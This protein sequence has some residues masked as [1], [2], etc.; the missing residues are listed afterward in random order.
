MIENDESPPGLGISL[1][2][3]TLVVVSLKPVRTDKA[4]ISRH[5]DRVLLRAVSRQEFMLQRDVL[6]SKVKTS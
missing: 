1:E 6:K 4:I 5:F 2:P 3:S